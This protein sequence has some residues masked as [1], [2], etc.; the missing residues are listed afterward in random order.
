[1]KVKGIG[2]WIACD[3]SEYVPSNVFCYILEYD[4]FFIVLNIISTTRE[5]ANLFVT[6]PGYM[7]WKLPIVLLNHFYISRYDIC[8]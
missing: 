6:C 1:M 2:R 7:Y 5:Q 4:F 8:L 3:T